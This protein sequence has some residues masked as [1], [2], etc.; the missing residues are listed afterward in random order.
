MRTEDNIVNFVIQHQNTGWLEGSYD[1]RFGLPRT[2]QGTGMSDEEARAIRI[3][4]VAGWLEYQQQVWTATDTYLETLDPD[5]MESVQVTIKPVG[6]MSLWQGLWGM[7]LSHG[8][9]HVGEIEFARGIQGLGG[10]S[11]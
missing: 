7:C 8:Y 9:R 11:I 6:E 3:E 10:L 5:S 4:D 2:A 1:E